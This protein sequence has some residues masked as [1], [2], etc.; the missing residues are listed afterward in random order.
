VCKP[1]TP[2]RRR[3]PYHP[4]DLSASIS[5]GDVE[6][7]APSKGVNPHP[8]GASKRLAVM[9]A[10]L[11]PFDTNRDGK[12]DAKE[13]VAVEQAILDGKLRPEFSGKP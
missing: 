2:S 10:T 1:K 5:N 11:L 7:P 12:I 4:A 6:L 3:H 13:G 9:Y 8:A